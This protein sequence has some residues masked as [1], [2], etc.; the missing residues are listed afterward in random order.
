MPATVVEPTEEK[1]S[2]LQKNKTALLIGA[3]VLVVGGGV[4]YVVKQ[5]RKKE[6]KPVE[7]IGMTNK[8]ERDSKGRFKGDGKATPKRKTQG[9]K[10]EKLVPT[11]LL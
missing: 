6:E 9:K 11:A 7:G 10:S 8:R 4:F 2:F 1:Q 3:G 5:S